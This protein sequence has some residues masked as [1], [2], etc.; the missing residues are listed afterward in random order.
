MADMC[1]KLSSTTL[2][3]WLVWP[4]AFGVARLGVEVG[5]YDGHVSNTFIKTLQF[6]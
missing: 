1:R 2:Q 5:G 3:F 4:L 6:L